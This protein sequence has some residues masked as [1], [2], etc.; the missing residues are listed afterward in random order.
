M[1]LRPGERILVTR[2]NYLGDVVLSLPLIDALHARHPG[3]E[4][5]YLTRDDG[6]ALLAGDARIGRVHRL[7]DG[8]AGAFRLVRAL[9]ARRYAAVIDLYSNP[10]SAWLTWFSGAPVRI[11]GNR[12]GR[13]HLYTHPVSVPREV[14]RVTDVFMRYGAA[15]GVGDVA[16]VPTLRLMPAERARADD[17]IA[18]AGARRV[19]PLIGVHPGGKWP[20]KRWPAGKFIELIAALG[21]RC[22]ADVLVFT[23]PTEREATD[24]LRAGT[25]PGVHVAPAMGVRELAA[26]VSRLDAMVA[27]DGGVMHVAAATGVPTVGIFGSSEPDIWFPYAG[28]GP[29]RAAYIDVPCRPC[30]R[31]ECPLGHT[32]CLNELTAGAVL[33]EI[34]G[35]MA[36]ARAGAAP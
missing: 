14:R 27:C 11:G 15:L 7:R 23:G 17:T 8:A 33:D 16:G 6:A 9:R 5:D 24:A 3:I 29:F 12:R 18:R 1:H 10:R 22:D 26:V 28:A 36:D 25:T 4:I 34:V 32:R 31:H 13:R 20:V 30:H 21:T 2:L 19:R 35:A